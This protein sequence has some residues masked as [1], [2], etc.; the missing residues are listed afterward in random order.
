MIFHI[1]SN[2]SNLCLYTYNQVP[3]CL[4]RLQLK[5][6]GALPALPMSVADLG[7]EQKKKNKKKKKKKK[8]IK[9]LHKQDTEENSFQMK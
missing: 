1:A 4:L 9:K 6:I 8:K 5:D 7:V 3:W 2:L